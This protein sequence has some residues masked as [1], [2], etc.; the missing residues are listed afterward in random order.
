MHR[1]ES[2]QILTIGKIPFYYYLTQVLLCFAIVSLSL[3][4][5]NEQIWNLLLHMV[6]DT[7]SYGYLSVR[8]DYHMKTHDQKHLTRSNRTYIEQELLQKTSFS[9]IAKVLHK[10]PTTIAKEVKRY[11][12]EVP[13]KY[14]YKCNLCTLYRECDLRSNELKCSSYN[15][16]YCSYYCKKCFRKRVIDLC[17]HFLPYSCDKD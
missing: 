16:R 17:P 5:V 2:Y 6:F 9:S 14:S 10:D 7:I 8:K 3:Y 13:G 12:K 1:R 15:V 11:H 4:C